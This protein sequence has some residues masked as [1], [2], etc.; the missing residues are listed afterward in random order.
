MNAG[1]L[2]IRKDHRVLHFNQKANRFLGTHLRLG[3]NRKIESV[4]IPADRQKVAAAIEQVFSTHEAVKNLHVQIVN[5]SGELQRMVCSIDPLLT[6]QSDEDA[7][8]L[9][10]NPADPGPGAHTPDLDLASSEHHYL[11]EALPEGVFTINTQWR[12]SWFNHTAEKITGYSREEV[13]GRYCW[14]IFRSDLCDISCPLRTALEKG[15]ISMDQDVRIITKQGKKLSILV[16][17]GVLKDTQGNIA[18]A[19]E[20]FRLL[21]GER[22]R[23]GP[24]LSR[25]TFSN[26]VGKSPAMRHLFSMLPDVAASEAN[27][28][29]CG[30]SGTGKDLFART[31]HNHS[32][33]RGKPFVAVNCTALAESLLESEMFGHEKAA[34]TGATNSKQGRFEMAEGGTIFLDEIGELKPDIQI[35]LLRVLEQREFE[36]VGGTRTLPM[37]ARIIAATNKD[38]PMAMTQGSFREDL[39][40]RLR[41][42]PL[43]IPP[44]RERPEDIPLLVEYFIT[45]LNKRHKKKV[46]AVS[47]D[48]MTFFQEY[49]W[50]GNVRELER[51][52]EYAYVFVKG[53][54]ILKRFLPASEEFGRRASA[55]LI[56]GRHRKTEPSRQNIFRALAE[57]DGNRTLAAAALGMSRTSLWRHM[58]ALNIQ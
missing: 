44:L 54:T 56:A 32:S 48:V 58:K 39:F 28:L 22:I 24:G 40:Y 36:R 23:T 26:I 12:I 34:F 10:L 52:L 20:T 55:R 7:V 19:V 15:R 41:T 3:E 16:N 57:T 21:V 50:P 51:T 43:T 29:I 30:E 6:G 47:P 17:A 46:R 33:R 25:Y 53:A 14:E 38:L 13:I 2:L 1:I 8:S 31:L 45:L 27:V 42:V 37:K 18:G 4:I 35:K 9:S 11:L 49:H 5:T